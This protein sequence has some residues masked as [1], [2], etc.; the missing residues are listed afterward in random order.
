[1]KNWHKLV[2]EW[3]GT[4]GALLMALNIPISGWGF[5][6]F[7][8]SSSIWAF[9]GF[10]AKEYAL[11]RMSAVYCVIDAFGIYRWLF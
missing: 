6:L 10:R 1:M 11:A 7:L 8:I 3:T 5:V 2:G 9:V 4:I